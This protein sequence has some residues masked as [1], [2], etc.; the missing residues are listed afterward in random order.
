MFMIII[1]QIVKSGQRFIDYKIGIAGAIVMGGIVYAINYFSTSDIAGSFTASLKQGMYTFILGGTLMKSCEYLATN[2][3]KRS[4]AIVASVVIPSVI[5]LLLTFS[6]H[7]LKGT[8]KPFASTIP[9]MI[10]VPAT[11]I[12]GLKKRKQQELKL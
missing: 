2:I 3:K 9:T 4:L 11:A 12:W 7:N 1:G 8:P 5:T 6:M 10:I